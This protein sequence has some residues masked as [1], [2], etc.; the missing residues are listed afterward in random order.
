MTQN[1]MEVGG[2]CGGMLGG[3]LTLVDGC[4]GRWWADGEALK[5]FSRLL[6]VDYSCM[7]VKSSPYH[8]F[9]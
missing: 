1:H 6:S 3:L 2:G 8:T 7:Y 5:M 9:M 4:W